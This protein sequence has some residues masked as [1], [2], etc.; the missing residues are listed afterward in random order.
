MSEREQ[1]FKKG[2]FWSASSVTL[3]NTKTKTA[4]DI[5]TLYGNAYSEG[6]DNR[7]SAITC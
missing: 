4:T 5:S 6:E 2:L 7:F 1:I 3:V